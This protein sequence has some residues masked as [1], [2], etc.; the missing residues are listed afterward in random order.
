MQELLLFG[1]LGFS[2]GLLASA[3]HS[4]QALDSHPLIHEQKLPSPW[5]LAHEGST[6]DTFPSLISFGRHQ[7][8]KLQK[9]GLYP[10]NTK[11]TVCSLAAADISQIR[12]NIDYDCYL[13]DSL[14][15]GVNMYSERSPF[16][17]PT[18]SQYYTCQSGYC[19]NIKRGVEGDNCTMASSNDAFPPGI[20]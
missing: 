19:I 13:W 11:E 1:R 2:L 10:I 3:F 20:T 14:N 5:M 15:N 12:C 16:G 4:T 17:F 8:K 18:A 7:N 9:R 6:D